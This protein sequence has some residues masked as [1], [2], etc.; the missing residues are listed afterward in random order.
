M[1]LGSVHLCAKETYFASFPLFSSNT[2]QIMY[3]LFFL[4]LLK[5]LGQKGEAK[6]KG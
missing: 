4:F 6:F 3:G 5:P 1:A 2:K